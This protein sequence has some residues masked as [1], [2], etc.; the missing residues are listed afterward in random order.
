MATSCRSGPRKADSVTAERPLHRAAITGVGAVTPLG[1]GVPSLLDAM[2]QGRQGVSRL[3]GV[4]IPRGK[5]TAGLIRDPRFDHPDRA[6][7]KAL[8]AASEALV[9]AAPDWGDGCEVGLLVATVWGDSG[10]AEQR[11]ADFLSESRPGEEL[12]TALRCFPNGSIADEL[13][14][15]CGVWGPRIVVSNACASGNIA[16]GIALDLMRLGACRAALVVGTENLNLTALWGADRAGFVGHALRPFHRL[17]DGAVLG[18]GAAA[19]VLEAPDALGDRTPLGWLEGFGCVCDKGAAAITLLEDGSGLRRSMDLAL[20][21]AGR[22]IDE[23][24]YVNA[25]APGTPLID[26]IECKAVADLTKERVGRVRVNSTKSLTT[27]LSAASA[28]VETIACLLQM[29]EGFLHPNAGLDDPDPELAAPVV[30]A[31]AVPHRVPLSLSNACGGGGLNTT[32]VLSAVDTSPPS[33]GESALEEVVVSGLGDLSALGEMAVGRRWEPGTK[34]P[35]L[36]DFDIGRWY[37]Q[38]SQFSF[39]NRA[40]QLAAAAG[41]LAIDDARLL[42]ARH[43]SDRVAVLA[44]T[45]LGG[46]PEASA[47]L[48]R[49]L[50]RD[51]DLIRPSMALDH[52]NHLGAALVCRHY[53]FNGP[54]YTFTGST[55]SSL[56][57]LVVAHDMLLRDRATAALVLGFDALD[58]PLVRA[59]RWFRDCFPPHPLGEGSA[60]LVVEHAASARRRGAALATLGARCLLAAPLDNVA[61]RSVAAD[62]L[63][64]GLDGAVWNEIWIAGGGERALFEVADRLAASVGRKTPF[65]CLAPLTNH[66]MA[67][68]GLLAAVGAVRTG[69]RVLVLAADRRGP[70]VALELLPLTRQADAAP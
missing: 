19:V 28:L 38:E 63:A 68:D 53:G 39:M 8:E 22:G 3:Q 41:A 42:E 7:R 61:A 47:V 52:G 18:E 36:E 11:F 43:A 33:S 58:G 31:A 14:E 1:V 56:T 50:A 48:C 49:G 35:R 55:T 62:R 66:C 60:A 25:H 9:S 12:L 21:D 24:C 30:G 20:R 67:A 4:P 57:A 27:H 16:L 40:A 26:R 29:R 37:P 5:D 59:S 6:V 34:T 10:A 70:V 69:E 13:G 51:P 15:R 44:G 17:R 2:R 64:A 54:T 45:W 46:G 65:R 32:V 23:V